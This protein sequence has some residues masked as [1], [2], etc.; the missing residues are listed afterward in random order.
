LNDNT[1]YMDRILMH[2]KNQINERLINI[3]RSREANQDRFTTFTYQSGKY[4]NPG[5][6]INNMKIKVTK[7]KTK[8]KS[9]RDSKVTADDKDQKVKEVA[10]TVIE[11]P[12]IEK[13]GP[14]RNDE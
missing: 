2:P 6:I 10:T 13:K 3:H 8:I 7:Q 9:P 4:Q 1:R 5:E 12:L 11:L 14:S